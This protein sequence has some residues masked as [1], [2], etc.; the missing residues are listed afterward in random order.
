M[1]R[2]WSRLS[3][4]VQA[5]IAALVPC[6]A[7]ALFGSVYFPAR[8]NRQATEAL[9]Q[10][11][12]ALGILGTAGSANVLARAVRGEIPMES[13]V[14]AGESIK[15][16]G[17]FEQVALFHIRNERIETENGALFFNSL[18]QPESR[19]AG[20]LPLERFRLPTFGACEVSLAEQLEVRCL[21]NDSGTVLLVVARRSLAPFQKLKADNQ[22]VGGWSLLIGTGFAVILALWFSGALT[23]PLQRISQTAVQVASGDVSLPSLDVGGAQEVQAMAQSVNG[24]MDGFKSMLTQLS[25]LSGNLDTAAS[26]LKSASAEQENITRQQSVYAQQIGSTF[27]QLAKNAESINRSTVMV[28]EAATKTNSAADEA[29]TVFEEMLREMNGIRAVTLEF[30]QA[31]AALNTELEH[32]SRIATVIQLVADRTDLLALNAA[33]EGSKAGEV[34]KGFTVVAAEMRK[35]SENIAQSARDIGAMVEQVQQS[36]LN[37]QGQAERGVSASVRLGTVADKAALA[38]AQMLDFSKGTKTAAQRIAV[39]AKQQR[40]SSEQAVQG[41]N[42]ITELVRRGVDATQK[43]VSIAGGLQTSVTA[44]TAMASRFKVAD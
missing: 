7:V 1:F 11:S 32:V 2:P 40:Q 5:V 23:K 12:R 8:L 43:T 6:M 34:G 29:Q 4:R 27:E 31:T 30:S 14:A 44:L 19:V 42:N 13:L 17:E 28:E 20:D 9:E 39:A 10:Q 41:S 22:R 16:A 38:F 3:L 15:V 37:A 18:A 24:M 26:E 36:S 35:L 21:G 25:S 33:L